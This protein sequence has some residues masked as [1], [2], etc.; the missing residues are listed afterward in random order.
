MSEQANN[1]GNTPGTRLFKVYNALLDEHRRTTNGGRFHYQ[2]EVGAWRLAMIS[3]DDDSVAFIVEHEQSSAIRVFTQDE[4]ETWSPTTSDTAMD[5][6][7]DL[8]MLA[9]Q[10]QWHLAPQG[11][12]TRDFDFPDDLM[13]ET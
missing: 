13:E 7:P 4:G 10:A 8:E 9:E 1:K 2:A 12:P 6:L 11:P 3:T 5:E